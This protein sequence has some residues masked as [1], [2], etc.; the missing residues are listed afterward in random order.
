MCSLDSMDRMDSM[1]RFLLDFFQRICYYM[2]I[3]FLIFCLHVCICQSLHKH[4]LYNL[5][6]FPFLCLLNIFI[7]NSLKASSYTKN[8]F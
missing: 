1:D 3:F 6:N 7:S 4:L 5:Y 8:V 2:N